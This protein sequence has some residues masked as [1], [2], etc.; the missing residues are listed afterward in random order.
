M[1]IKAKQETKLK[2]TKPLQVVHELY[3]LQ[4]KNEYMIIP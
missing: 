3:P 4:K 1:S 2:S